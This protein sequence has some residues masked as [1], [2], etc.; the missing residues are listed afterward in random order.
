MPNSVGLKSWALLNALINFPNVKIYSINLTEVLINDYLILK[1]SHILKKN[2][3]CVISN[4][5][6]T[7]DY[8][9][10]I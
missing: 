1:K 2:K 4:I 3:I 6:Q 10:N 7:I 8:K 9:K 5:N